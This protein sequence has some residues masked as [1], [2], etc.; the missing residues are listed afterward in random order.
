[1][2][3]I[4]EIDKLVADAIRDSFKKLGKNVSHLSDEEI[5]EKAEI[6]DKKTKELKIDI[7]TDGDEYL[8]V[9]FEVFGI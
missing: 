7:N 6:A 1:M 8:R 3:N 9:T 2:E 4:Q 5:K